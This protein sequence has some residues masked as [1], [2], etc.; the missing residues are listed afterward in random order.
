M[1]DTTIKVSIAKLGTSIQEI[2]IPTGSNVMVALR[3]AG[4]N[5]DGV[6]SVKRNWTVATLDTALV[7]TDV[8]L[9]S[10]EKIKGW[11]DDEPEASILRLAFTIEKENA[12]PANNGIMFEDTMSTWEIV[13]QVMHSR[14]ISLNSFKEI[15]DEE[16]NVL[17]LETKFEDNKAYKIIVC[18]TPNCGVESDDDCYED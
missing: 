6:V 4:F 7:D 3:K 5:L 16:G 2:E 12:S 10:M 17:P 13:K 14:W 11:A 8:L 15:Q 1:T 9:V 18:S